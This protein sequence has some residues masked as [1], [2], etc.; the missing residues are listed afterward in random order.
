[1]WKT[2]KFS[3]HTLPNEL[4]LLFPFL[5]ILPFFQRDEEK[6][7]VARPRETQQAESDNTGRRFDAGGFGQQFFD[8]VRGGLCPLQRRSAGELKVHVHV[9]LVLI[10][11][12][13]GGQ[14]CAEEARQDPAHNKDS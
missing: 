6:R 2:S 14:L 1:M 8:I 4:I 9:T 3:V 12:K 7:A 5:A 10:R 13:A 11:K